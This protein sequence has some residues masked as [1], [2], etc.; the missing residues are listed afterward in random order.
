MMTPICVIFDLD[1]TLVDSEGLCSRGFLDLLLQLGDSLDDFLARYR[2]QQ[3]A[4]IRASLEQRLGGTL[5]ADFESRYRE[6]VAELF[7]LELSPVAGV[8]PMLATLDLPRCVASNGPL[9]KMRQSLRLAGIAGYFGERLYSAYEVGSWKPDPGLFL[10]AARAMG[11]APASCVV[12][13]DSEVGVRAAI[14]AGMRV[15][16]YRPDVQAATDLQVP[17]FSDMARLPALLARMP[18]AV[19]P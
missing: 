6:R 2:G 1:G 19:S 13:E 18:G 16:H 14:A 4:A 17:N 5:P 8:A 12:V 11:F 7:E 9:P 3:F 15:L 10:H